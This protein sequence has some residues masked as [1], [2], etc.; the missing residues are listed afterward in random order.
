MIHTLCLLLLTVFVCP[1]FGPSSWQV[2]IGL[3]YHEEFAAR[4]PRA[5]VQPCCT[6]LSLQCAVL[7]HAPLVTSPRSRT[8]SAC[9]VRGAAVTFDTAAVVDA[10]QLL[11]PKR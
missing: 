9:K 4:I 1:A 6:P 11:H 5:E 7:L 10:H 2:E 8:S 3:R